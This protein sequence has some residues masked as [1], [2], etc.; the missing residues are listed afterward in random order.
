MWQLSWINSLN[1]PFVTGIKFT[2]GGD[3]FCAMNYYDTILNHYK[4][5]IMR[6]NNPATIVLEKQLQN[7]L[8]FSGIE[9]MPANNF[10]FSYLKKRSVSDTLK[11]QLLAARFMTPLPPIQAGVTAMTVFTSAIIAEIVRGGLN[12]FPKD[13]GRQPR[14]KDSATGRRCVLSFCPKPFAT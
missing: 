14:R 1:G 3:L 5:G 13:N 10:L 7:M 2:S 8:G 4:P 12:S 6:V 9:N 11:T